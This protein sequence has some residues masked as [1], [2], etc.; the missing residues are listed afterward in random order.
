MF[1]Y[2]LIFFNSLN[3]DYSD[4]IAQLCLF[5]YGH[6]SLYGMFDSRFIIYID[7]WLDIMWEIK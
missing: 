2:M 5:Y 1:K 4:K 6:C 7:N 3:F